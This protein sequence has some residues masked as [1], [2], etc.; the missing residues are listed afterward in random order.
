MYVSV[1]VKF[2]FFCVCREF[3][4]FC[5]FPLFF[6]RRNVS[7]P[8]YLQPVGDVRCE[9]VMY[10][11]VYVYATGSLRWRPLNRIRKFTLCC[12]RVPLGDVVPKTIVFRLLMDLYVVFPQ[13]TIWSYYYNTWQTQ[14]GLSI[15]LPD[16]RLNYHR[17]PLWKSS[18][19]S[20][21]TDIIQYSHLGGTILLLVW[22]RESPVHSY[23]GLRPVDISV[24]FLG[25]VPW[26]NWFI[27]LELEGLEVLTLFI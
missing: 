23:V 11:N 7:R 4:T 24:L 17:P 9:V 14:G 25:V 21:S 1:P 26:F 2:S 3:S 18:I 20:E 27:G 15:Q 8:P 16:G 5:R 10:F 22:S 13:F 6:V 19:D 12:I